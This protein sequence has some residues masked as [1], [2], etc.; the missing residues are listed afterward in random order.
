MFDANN[1]KFDALKI[2]L[3]SPQEMKSW[4]YG[5][6]TKA[7][8]INY[9][10][11]KPE[12]GGLFDERIFGPTKDFECA[13]GKYK[14][15]RFKGVVCDKCGVEVTY[16][17]VRRERMGHIELAAPVVHTW[18]FKRSP[19][20]LPVIL[21]VGLRDLESVI[22]FAQFLVVDVD[23]EKRQEVIERLDRELEAKKQ[24]LEEEVNARIEDLKK[25]YEEKVKEMTADNKK[26]EGVELKLE[27]LEKQHKKEV[28][29]L[30]DELIK[31]Q[32]EI[33]ESFKEVKERINSIKRFSIISEAEMAELD[34]WEATD[35]FKAGMGAE[36][37]L[38]AINKIDFDEEIEKLNA[39]IKGKSKTKRKKAI[40]RLKIIKGMKEAHIDP[41]WMILQVIPV[42]PPE[43]RPI[44]QLPGGRFATSDLNDLYRRVI[45]RNNRLND[46]IRLGAPEIILQNEKRMLQESV[47]SLIEGTK[48]ITRGRKELQSLSDMLKGK[49]G[50]FRQNLLGKRV[51]YSGR[52]VI[53]V[54][55]NLKMHQVGLP[56]EMA[57]EL[58][59][60][61]VLR[62]L[63]LEGYA[64]NL[65][66]AKHVLEARG[67][68]VWDI[69]ERVTKDHPV[70]LN[71][72]PTLHRQNIQAFYPVLIEGKAITFHPAIV[73]SFAG[74]FD[75]DQ[76]AVHVPLSKAAIKEAKERLLSV[77]NILK[78]AHGKPIFDLKHDLSLGLY[79]LTIMNEKSDKEPVVFYGSEEVMSAYQNEQIGLHDHIA[80]P[81]NGEK[82]ITTPG[83]VIFNSILP[84]KL[85]FAN[86][87]VNR[88]VMRGLI[89][90]CF[91]EYGHETTIE[92]IDNFKQYGR[93]YST[94]MGASYSIADFKIPEKRDDVIKEA[95]EKIKEIDSNYQLGLMTANE[96]HSQIVKTWEE[97]TEKIMELVMDDIDPNSIIGML[98]DSKAFKANPETIRQVEGIRG[99]MVDSKGVIKETPITTTFLEGQTSFDGYLNMVGGRKSLIDVAL[100]TA[101]AGYLTRRL[102]DVS[103]DVLVRE[104]DCGTT[105]GITV[106][107]HPEVQDWNLADRI[108]GRISVKTIKAGN[109]VLVK[110]GEMITP[111]Q[112]KQIVDAGITEVEVRSPLTCRT[113]HGVCSMCYGKDLGTRKLVEVGEAVGVIAAQS[114]GEPGTQL[115]LHSKHRA[116]AAKKEITQGL[117]RVE[118]LFEA[119]TPKVTGLI[120]DVAGTV[121]RIEEEEGLYNIFITTDG[122]AKD[123]E[124]RK[125]VVLNTVKVLVKEGDKVKLGDQITEG[126]LNLSEILELRG[127]VPLQ[128][129][130]LQEIQGVYK[131]Q[132]VNVNDKHIEIIIR[133]MT[134]KVT[135]KEPGDSGLLPG[136]YIDLNELNE[137]NEKLVAEGKEPARGSRAL[138]GISKAALHTDSWLSAAS[139]EETTNVLAS[140]SVNERPNIDRLLGLKEN[141]I[142][143]RLIPTNIKSLQETEEEKEPTLTEEEQEAKDFFAPDA[144][145]ASK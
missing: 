38:E 2:S 13:C 53:V 49:Q 55:P 98:L 80:I 106:V 64:P 88:D 15:Q 81:F 109:K 52:S 19:N 124:V 20:K 50:R 89:A 115:T 93:V 17:R 142:I 65:K 107:D 54:G 66:S 130:L 24:E 105:E 110:K 116:G 72:A 94:V 33:A 82:L 92:M 122:K 70:L 139:F 3:A 58:F 12:K 9:R 99:L 40:K 61:F 144:E 132:G 45:N 21:D 25:E 26:G 48:K 31:N 119:R 97:A 103:H 133:K 135:I 1:Y 56:K 120:A 35:F 43:L 27:S 75:G 145:E 8:T 68:E 86:K 51:D 125:Y 121:S 90:Q 128:T 78:L 112:A 60:P 59:K 28:L 46:L 4:S 23:D 84:E 117:P 96:R 123:Q 44:V 29:Y 32:D 39:I 63:I 102:V 79:Y 131:S 37:I 67:D 91:D 95:Q 62:D 22:Y 140:A 74:D 134:E 101:A 138:L 34:F 113:K 127:V 10:T 143:G 18:Y 108:E 111:E 104:E 87:T 114:I 83:R 42:I 16:S 85:R 14:R 30:R 11:L 118:Q 136:D 71:R 36:I 73:G 100:L 47:D 57:L 129:Y 137:L 141:V 77:H 69:L 126:M 6:V 5:E 76:M 41:S 7:E